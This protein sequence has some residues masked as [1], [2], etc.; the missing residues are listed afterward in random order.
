MRLLLD[1]RT[2]AGHQRISMQLLEDGRPRGGEFVPPL[3]LL[4]DF[5]PF[6][7]RREPGGMDRWR[8]TWLDRLVSSNEG[9]EM[10]EPETT[11]RG[12]KTRTVV[13][14][15][16]DHPHCPRRMIVA[17]ACDC[18]PQTVGW[19][20]SRGLVPWAD[21][22]LPRSQRTPAKDVPYEPPNSPSAELVRLGQRFMNDLARGITNSPS[23]TEWAEA[24]AEGGRLGLTI[25]EIRLSLGLEPMAPPAGDVVDPVSIGIGLNWP[26]VGLPE[27]VT[28]RTTRCVHERTSHGRLG[29]CRQG[30]SPVAT[31]RD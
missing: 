13:Q 22:A 27:T 16:R 1:V 29:T 6:S 14:F 3:F 10:P 25:N 9:G 30:C 26:E 12:V 4:D 23:V 24:I 31:T 18:T 8:R 2:V 28:A 17:E 19:V 11:L 7:V 5:A 15:L 20:I 21:L